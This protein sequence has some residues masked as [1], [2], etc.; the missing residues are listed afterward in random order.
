[1]FTVNS[2]TSEII[3]C[4]RAERLT[5][6][7]MV[8]GAA[9]TLHTAVAVMPCFRPSCSTVITATLEAIFR[10]T[11]LKPSA[12]RPGCA[13][14]LDRGCPSSGNGAAPFISIPSYSDVFANI[15][16]AFQRAEYLTRVAHRKTGSTQLVLL[17]DHPF[18]HPEKIGSLA[19]RQIFQQARM[20]PIDP[21]PQLGKQLLT[22]LCQ[23]RNLRTAVPLARAAFEQARTGHPR[24]DFRQIGAIQPDAKG[25]R[26]LLEIGGIFQDEQY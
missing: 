3:G 24:D 17:L 21:R 9:L 11:S 8:G 23:P 6:M 18:H 26:K 14:P 22:P 12:S 4:V 19:G 1:M 20:R 13:T 15:V 25:Q 2:L 16:S 7:R 10:M 5:T